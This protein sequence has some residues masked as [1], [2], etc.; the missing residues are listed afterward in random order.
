MLL[1]IPALLNADELAH[2]RARLRDA[3]WIDGRETAGVQSAKTK[4]NLQLPRDSEACR[5]LG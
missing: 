3:Q 1:H 5:E 4:N 2:C